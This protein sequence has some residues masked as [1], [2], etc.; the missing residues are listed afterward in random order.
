MNNASNE[1]KQRT[2]LFES[3]MAKQGAL[4]LPG[5]FGGDYNNDQIAI[6]RRGAAIDILL[7]LKIL[8]KDG[9]LQ[10][11]MLSLGAFMQLSRVWLNA[12]IACL[13]LDANTKVVADEIEA[14]LKDGKLLVGAVYMGR[15]GGNTGVVKVDLI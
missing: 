10:F 1:A 9:S 12:L 5:R 6:I 15:E 7:G 8:E 14:A 13:K 2:K 4:I 11:D 3:L